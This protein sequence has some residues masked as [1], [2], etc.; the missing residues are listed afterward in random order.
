MKKMGYQMDITNNGKSA[1]E[2]VKQK[3]YD[4][5]FMDINM[6]KMDG[7][8]ATTKI[9]NLSSIQ[10]PYII[11]LTAHAQDKDRKKYLGIGMNDH[12]SK[13]IDFD[14]LTKA[15]LKC[16]SQKISQT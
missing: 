15:L 7:M 12:V 5:I 2:A 9:R 6:P 13:P 11:A 16:P 1:L 10:Q 8:E 3:T 14:S 4:L